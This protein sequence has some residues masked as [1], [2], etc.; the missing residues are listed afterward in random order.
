MSET[1][2]S[3]PEPRLK[4]QY[5][6]EIVPALMKEFSYRNVMQVPRLE[7]ISVNIGLGEAIQNSLSLIH[8]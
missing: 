2:E 5:R 1:K 6:D 7:K 4:L 3:R 8:I